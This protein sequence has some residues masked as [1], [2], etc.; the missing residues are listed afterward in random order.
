MNKSLVIVFGLCLLA[1][2]YAKSDGQKKKSEPGA[3]QVKRLELVNGRGEVVGILGT[4]NDQPAIQ[5]SGSDGSVVIKPGLIAVVTGN[6][7]AIIA[8]QAIGLD[9]GNIRAAMTINGGKPS[10]MTMQDGKPVW[11]SDPAP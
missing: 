2:A 10:I 11:N 1:V 8:G 6:N 3:I 9:G 5:L 7:K 4:S